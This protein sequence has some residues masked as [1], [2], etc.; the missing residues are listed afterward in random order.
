MPG[1]KVG[2]IGDVIRDLPA[3]LQKRGHQCTV[4]MP[5][6]GALSQLPGTKKIAVLRTSFGGAAVPRWCI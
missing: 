4:L 6:Y 2:G 3:A 1:G 5:G